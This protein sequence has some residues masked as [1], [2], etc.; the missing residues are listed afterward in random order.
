M[1]RL[2]IRPAA[3][4]RALLLLLATGA[5]LAAGCDAFGKVRGL[6]GSG[7]DDAPAPLSPPSDTKAE[8]V[9]VRDERVSGEAETI[10]KPLA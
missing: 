6:F 10:R 9:K 4:R 3:P 1:T 8:I 7:S 2:S 5:C